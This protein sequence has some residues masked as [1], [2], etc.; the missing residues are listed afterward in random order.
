MRRTRRQ[1]AKRER[2]SS[3]DLPIKIQRTASRTFAIGG[4]GQRILAP[5]TISS[6]ARNMQGNALC[7]PAI[8]ACLM[9]QLADGF[10]NRAG[11]RKFAQFQLLRLS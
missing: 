3:S 7:L 6:P 5:M 2:K 8:H 4:N 10:E 9:L 1:K 11:T